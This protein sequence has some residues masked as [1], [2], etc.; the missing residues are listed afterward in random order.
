MTCIKPWPRSTSSKTNQTVLKADD[1]G[2]GGDIK[3]MKLLEEVEL[4]MFFFAQSPW[5]RQRGKQP[6]KQEEFVESFL[7]VMHPQHRTSLWRV[8][9]F[10]LS[11]N[12]F[13]PDDAKLPCLDD[14]DI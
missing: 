6:E 7:K 13:L 2:R 3:S 8:V 14:L 5:D 4:K 10:L 11:D 12:A 9:C 1:F